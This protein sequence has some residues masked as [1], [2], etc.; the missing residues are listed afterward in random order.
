MDALGLFLV[1]L[2]ASTLS[3]GGLS[4]LPLLHQ[5]LVAT[6]LATDQQ[7][8]QA[9]AIGRLST[10]PN[11]LWVVSLGYLVGGWSGATAAL[12]AASVPPLVILPATRLA[13]RWLLSRWFS[14]LVRGVAFATGGL[15]IATGIGI[16]A[17]SGDAASVAWW[18]FVLLAFAIVF[19]T[20]GRP[21]P[22]LLIVAGA[23]VGIELA[24]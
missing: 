18:Q 20:R 2:K 8:V 11:G 5:D 16:L 9:I 22:A 3:M 19:T 12:V 14:G 1:F 10:G 24:R 15:L 17:S 13:R 4:S 21:H 6:G 23:V 7:V